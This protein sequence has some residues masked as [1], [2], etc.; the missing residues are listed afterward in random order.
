MPSS[1]A[2]FTD[3]RP[4]RMVCRADRDERLLEAAADLEVPAV[5]G[6]DCDAE[7]GMSGLTMLRDLGGRVVMDLH[8]QARPSV[9]NFMEDAGR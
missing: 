3:L 1:S 9:W 4:A 8:G 5:G 2:E 6:D 7:F